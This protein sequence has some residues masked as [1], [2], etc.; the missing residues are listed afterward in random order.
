MRR[1]RNAI[2]NLKKKTNN[3][4]R[5]LIFI[6]FHNMYVCVCVFVYNTLNTPASQDSVDPFIFS[7]YTSVTDQSIK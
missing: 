3:Y 1:E 7:V 2:T 6:L 5:A 4:A